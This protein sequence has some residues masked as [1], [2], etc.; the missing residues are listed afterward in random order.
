VNRPTFAN[1]PH[2]DCGSTYDE[3]QDTEGDPVVEGSRSE[4]DAYERG[5]GDSEN[6]HDADNQLAEGVVRHTIS[7]RPIEPQPSG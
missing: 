7:M 1:S 3:A 2:Q 5:R 4:C 6:D